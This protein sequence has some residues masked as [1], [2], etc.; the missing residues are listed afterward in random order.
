MAGIV[1]E[2]LRSGGD[3]SLKLEAYHR[4][5]TQFVIETETPMT[6]GVQ[7]EWGSGKTSLLNQ[8]W[9]R[10]ETD[11][12]LAQSDRRYR[13]IW[14]NAWEHSLLCSPEECLLKVINEIIQD[15][16]SA[17]PS[18]KKSETLKSTMLMVAKGIARVGGQVVAGSAGSSIA[19]ELF[20]GGENT[21]K[22]LRIQLAELVQE[23]KTNS[24]NP[25]QKVIIYVDDLDRINPPDAVR[26][27][28]LLK[29][30]FNL[31]D[32]VFILAIDYGVVVKGLEDKFGKPTPENE[33]EFRA[34][35]DKIIQLP[36]TMPMGRYD[37]ANYVMNLLV[38]IDYV[39]QDE[40]LDDDFLRE[41]IR[42]SIGGNPRSIKRLINS[43]SLIKMF[44]LDSEQLEVSGPEAEDN[45]TLLL[46]LVCIQIA[47]PQIYDL[48]LT[49]PDFT[50]WSEDLAYKITQKKEE[51]LDGWEENFS[52]VKE[53]EEFDEAWEQCIFRICY[54]SPRNRAKA[55]HISMLL[56]LIKEKLFESQEDALV[57]GIKEALGQSAVT[58]VSHQESPNVRPEKGSYKRFLVSGFDE[59]VEQRAKVDAGHPESPRYETLKIF[60]NFVD[61]AKKNFDATD[62]QSGGNDYALVYAGGISL[63]FQK[64]KIISIFFSGQKK[65]DVI[66]IEI[67]RHPEH[68]PRLLNL[69]GIAFKK[70]RHG[71]AIE[72]GRD[73]SSVREL[74][75][76]SFRAEWQLASLDASIF[77]ENQQEI[78]TFLINYS[79][80]AWLSGDVMT[81]AKFKPHED[82]FHSA[83]GHSPKFKEAVRVI[84]E[85][86]E[87]AEPHSA[88]LTG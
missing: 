58:S 21:I 69:D 88:S 63:S 87:E 5:L 72:A 57:S 47:Y 54:S 77:P 26:I 48:L 15:L 22:K 70:V 85:Y 53:Q 34:F 19:D 56:S 43:L 27:L 36:F 55:S 59:W 81:Q 7:G 71:L 28:E 20:Q 86:F 65:R 74:S 9:H 2:A 24:S 40:G 42:L 33:W 4:A 16:I 23:I 13:Q 46:A 8:I 10:L 83:E 62:E 64:R 52:K 30:I 84:E 3:D 49:E 17:D 78:W 76:S 80:E 12:I 41:L 11:K 50:K 14:I 68:R 44:G 29:N 39:S 66:G 75:G 61:C 82:A 37:I 38:G 18:T 73:G 6:I 1:D 60:K 32:C 25:Y 67:Y 35:F 51:S 79:R 31:K 45:G